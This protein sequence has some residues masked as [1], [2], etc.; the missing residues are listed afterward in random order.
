MTMNNEKKQTITFFYNDLSYTYS[1]EQ[2]N[3]NRE[4]WE[5]RVMITQKLFNQ[6]LLSQIVELE[7]QLQENIK[8][9]NSQRQKRLNLITKM[10]Y[11]CLIASQELYFNELGLEKS[12]TRNLIYKI[13]YEKLLTPVLM[14]EETQ[15]VINLKD[16]I[17]EVDDALKKNSMS[18]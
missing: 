5:K 4:E 14:D 13:T 1:K 16:L 17:E 2:E 9:K 6:H 15:K 11:A 12:P 8:E 18:F 3:A 10:N 7:F